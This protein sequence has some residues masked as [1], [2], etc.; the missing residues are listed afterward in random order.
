MSVLLCLAAGGV[1]ASLAVGR[2][3]L[4]WQHSIEKT[5]WRES[6]AVSAAGLMPVEAR[7]QGTGA[8]MEPPPDA[9]LKDGWF[10]WRPTLPP[11]QKLSYPD[12]AYTRPMRLCLPGRPCRPLRSFL[13][14]GAPKDQ[15]VVLSPSCGDGRCRCG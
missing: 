9:R 14:K 11:Q 6:W 15:P 8:G 12:S 13:P 7:V 3:T 4:S 1:S 5:E 10:I 2:F